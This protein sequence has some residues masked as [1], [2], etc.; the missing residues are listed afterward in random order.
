MKKCFIPLFILLALSQSSV[1]QTNL[2]SPINESEIR[3]SGERQIVPQKYKTHRLNTAA[4][5]SALF[6]APLETNVKLASSSFIIELPTPNGNI[7][8]FH[9]IESPI[10]ETALSAA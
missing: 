9:L 6:S 4:F 10:M 7:Q 3:V 5:K 1:S 8:R 2:W